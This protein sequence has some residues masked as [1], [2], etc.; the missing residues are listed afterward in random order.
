MLPVIIQVSS[1]SESIPDR[2]F[3]KI[4]QKSVI[5]FLIDRIKQEYSDDIVLAA[6]D[7]P[8]DDI[9]EK[10]AKNHNIRFY[11]GS[12]QRCLTRIV[13]AARLCDCDNFIRVFANAP[14][15]D[16]EQMK[17]MAAAHTEGRYDY[18]YDEHTS[19]LMIGGGC[20]IFNLEFVERLLAD[21]LHTSQEETISTYIRQNEERFRI[22]RYLP[23]NIKKYYYRYLLE[24]EKDLE[25]INDIASNVVT[26]T[27]NAIGEYLE[28]HPVLARYNLEAPAKEVG[29]DKFYMHP[30]KVEAVMSDGIDN[31]YPIS[32]E[33]TLTNKCNLRCVYCSDQM[34]RERQGG[35]SELT[36]DTL[37]KLFEDLSEG[38]TQGV[39]IEGGGE[40]TI[41]PAFEEVVMH[42]RKCGLAAGLIT[43]GTQKLSENVLKNLEWIR[44]SL[45]ATTADEYRELKGPDFFERVLNNISH[46]TQHCET[47][48]VGFVVTRKNISHLEELVMRLKDLGVSYIQ[49]R[50]VVDSPDLYPEGVDLSYLKYF[51]TD[52]FG[53]IIDGMTENAESG[54]HSLPCYAN[55]VTSI[56]SGDGS[57]YLC[58][59]LNIYKWVKP[60][61][62]I[63]EH[64]FHDIWFGS[65][66][67]RQW[68]IV[69]SGNFCRVNCPQCRVS[70]LNVAVD[71]MKNIKSKHF[72]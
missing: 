26:F 24:S 9:Y 3:R 19:G 59:R 56:I 2:C 47:V 30:L 11:R 58:G 18:S 28:K 16:I 32:V 12:W 7:L 23:Q 39:T 49:L 55:S 14:F 51:Q 38:G 4:G 6:S 15:V 52:R 46:Y 10:V 70:K 67:K 71:R 22:L 5:D 1:K 45:D 44:V 63:N 40:P 27:N 17:A 29:L 25:V 13:G 53:V 37:F 57:V 66:R 61:G 42:A 34:L 36:K 62:N 65:E 72:I 69:Q 50:P 48:G 31:T 8:E 43:N 64:S 54:N 20:D 35:G 41:Y 21:G 68:E 33:L 60:M